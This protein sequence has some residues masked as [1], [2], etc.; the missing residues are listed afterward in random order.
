MTTH[1]LLSPVPEIECPISPLTAIWL[2]HVLNRPDEFPEFP[3]FPELRSR[4]VY[5]LARE[6]SVEDLIDHVRSKRLSLVDAD[7]LVESVCDLNP[8]ALRLLQTIYLPI[9]KMDSTRVATLVEAVTTAKERR[10][11]VAWVVR[12]IRTRNEEIEPLFAGFG[13][14]SIAISVRMFN[15]DPASNLSLFAVIM[16]MGAGCTLLGFSMFFFRMRATR[17]FEVAERALI[18][19]GDAGPRADRTKEE[20]PSV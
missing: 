16:L 20:G 9:K 8:Y 19:S 2:I 12:V 13:L 6:I 5:A 10:Y 3:A 15:R 14:A 4:L 18:A 7:F 11:L 1:P 17:A